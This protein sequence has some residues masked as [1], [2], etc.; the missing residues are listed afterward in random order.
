MKEPWAK[1]KISELFFAF[2]LNLHYLS[3]RQ[4]ASRQYAKMNKFFFCI[5]LNLHYLCIGNCQR[6]CRNSFPNT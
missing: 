2:A 3:I 6:V 4:A 5:A 1:R